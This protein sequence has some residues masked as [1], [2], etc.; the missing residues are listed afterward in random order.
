M[1]NHA[2]YLNNYSLYD[3]KHN[4]KNYYDIRQKAE[5]TVEANSKSKK[6]KQN[7]QKH[8]VEIGLADVY[9]KYAHQ[10]DWSKK[11]IE[12]N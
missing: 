12:K 6:N 2:N 11:L 5:L 7:I 9:K 1:K 10:C 3:L 4:Q 8:L